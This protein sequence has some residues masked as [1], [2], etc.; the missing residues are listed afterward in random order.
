MKRGSRSHLK[1]KP[2][3]WSAPSDYSYWPT[4]PCSHMFSQPEPHSSGELLN[5]HVCLQACKVVAQVTVP[6]T[7][8]SLQKHSD[9]AFKGGDWKGKRCCF[10]HICLPSVKPSVCCEDFW[11]FLMLS[12][13]VQMILGWVPTLGS[14]LITPHQGDAL[15]IFL[16]QLHS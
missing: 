4:G 7:S 3:S 10:L 8:H 2:I 15:N 5:T 13:N 12:C 6:E 9:V 14:G 11:E 1:N 16:H